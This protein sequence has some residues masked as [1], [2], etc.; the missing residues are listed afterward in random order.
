MRILSWIITVPLVVVAVLFALSNRG[1]VTLR[2]W[3]LPFEMDAPLYLASLLFLLAGF[4]AGGLVAWISGHRHRTAARKNGWRMQ[5]LERDLADA[6]DRAAQ[7]EKRVAEL[8][9]PPVSLPAGTPLPVP[10]DPAA[11]ALPPAA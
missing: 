3:P 4:I 10:A 9:R 2:L 8:T 7:A 1:I 5:K 11:K 6:Q